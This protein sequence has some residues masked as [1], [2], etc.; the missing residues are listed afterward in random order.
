MSDHPSAEIP[1]RE[2]TEAKHFSPW[3]GG[4]IRY[5]FDNPVLQ[6]TCWLHDLAHR[7][8]MDYRPH[9]GFA[10]FSAKMP[11]LE[12][13]ATITS[14]FAIYLDHPSLREAIH[15]PLHVDRFLDD[16]TF[17]RFWK[18]S[19]KAAW[20]E[21]RAFLADAAR[22]PHPSDTLINQIYTYGLTN[23]AWLEIWRT[24]YVEVEQQ[25]EALHAQIDAGTPWAIAAEPWQQWLH[26][27]MGSGDHNIPFFPQALAFC[28][29]YLSIYPTQYHSAPL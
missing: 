3:W 15:W 22:S 18:N 8:L 1:L 25:M 12:R 5:Q 6:D 21:L 9:D 17:T 13:E 20:A 23:Q 26:A 27:S 19:R 24:R 11:R 28:E 10:T 4:I 29:A 14:N 16:P 7:S 2:R